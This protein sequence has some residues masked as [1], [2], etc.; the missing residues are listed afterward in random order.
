MSKDCWLILYIV[1]SVISL[2]AYLIIA[3]FV[4]PVNVYCDYNDTIPDDA[5]ISLSMAE[6]ISYGMI[7]SIAFFGVLGSCAKSKSN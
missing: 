2:L 1:L 4:T 6:W 5:V 7:I 3:I